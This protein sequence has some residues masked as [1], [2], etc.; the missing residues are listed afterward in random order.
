MIEEMT[1]KA[2]SLLFLETRIIETTR[3]LTVAVF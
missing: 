1:E 3:E 2:L